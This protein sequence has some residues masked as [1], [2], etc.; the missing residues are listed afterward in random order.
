[1]SLNRRGMHVYLLPTLALA[2]MLTGCGFQLRGAEHTTLPAVRL[3]AEPPFRYDLE[4]VLQRSDISVTADEHA[5]MVTLTNAHVDYRV[6]SM[7]SRGTAREYEVVHTVHLAVQ[8]GDQ[9]LIPPATLSASRIYSTTETAWL[10]SQAEAQQA[11]DAAA[12]SLAGQILSRLAG[13]KTTR[14]PGQAVPAN[15]RALD[16][17]RAE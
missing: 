8:C 3:D 7:D 5:P 9:N 14:C 6:L 1:M 13:I 16:E 10:G 17:P 4:H 12:K 11:A 2:A 15:A